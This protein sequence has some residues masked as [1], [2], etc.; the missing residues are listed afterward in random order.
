MEGHADII[1]TI[2]GAQS[3]LASAPLD[4][5]LHRQHVA[6]ASQLRQAVGSDGDVSLDQAWE[7]YEEGL[8]LDESGSLAVDERA[9]YGWY[10]TDGL[11]RDIW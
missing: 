6:A 3:A 8:T 2:A 9:T 10:R 11:T 7:T 4:R 1:E 5:T